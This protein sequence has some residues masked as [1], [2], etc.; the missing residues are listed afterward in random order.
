MK[1]S[2]YTYDYFLESFHE[3]KASA[4]TMVSETDDQTLTKKPDKESWS[5]IEILNHLVQAG[6]EYLPQIRKALDRNDDKLAKGSGPFT[7]GIFFRWFIG[8]V[9]PENPRKLPTVSSFKPVNNSK[10]DIEK[11]LTDF[12]DLQDAFIHVLKRAKLEGLDLNRIKAK[13]PIIKIIP[14]SLTACFGVADAHQRRHFDQM[15]TL[16]NSFLSQNH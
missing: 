13:N 16:K 6:N 5:M 11:T 7:P 12:L 2:G 9:S 8:Q 14:M 10:L 1:N 4:T 3:A 15:K